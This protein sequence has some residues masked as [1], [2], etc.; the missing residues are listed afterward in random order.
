MQKQIIYIFLLLSVNI[1]AQPLEQLLNQV[2]E[3]NLS[4]KVLE[5]NYY[6]ALEKAPQVSQRPDPEIGIG[7]FPLPVETRLGGQT[8]RLSA[9]QMF[10]W[11]GT[12]EDKEGVAIA[13]ARV[14]HQR[15]SAEAL[16][17]Q[18]Q[19]EQAY[20]QLYESK[21]S[22]RIIERNL[23]LLEALERLALV[24]VESGSAIA[25]DVLRVQ[26][27][28][29]ALKQE[30]AIWKTKFVA[31][32]TTINQILNRP[33]N[34]SIVTK[35]S[36]VFAT[37][38][39]NRDSLIKNIAANHPMLHVMALQQ[40]VAKQEIAVNKSGQKPSF[41]VGLDY[42]TVD[43]RSDAM[44]VRN[45]RDI[46]QIKGVLRIPL[47]KGKFEA[48]EKEEQFK[49]EAINHKK[50]NLLTQFKANIEKAFAIYEAA[51]LQV[52]L[53]QQQIALTKASIRILETNYSTNGKSFDE[54][55]RLQKDLID[56]DLK[57]LRAIVQSHLAK[58]DMER[59]ISY[60]IK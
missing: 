8:L 20:F 15:I 14:Q 18:Y 28:V 17:L 33:L 23:V 19:I 26:L 27:Q 24:K 35:D 29:A 32:T 10:P 58:S 48:K 59:Y 45:G 31:P 60:S 37:L 51:Q 38:Y 25:A 6:A 5:N 7:V 39:Y 41:G 57:I 50:T 53:Y 30:I 36:L 43:K 16:E 42:I 56:Y 40:E 2:A 55:L 21:Q 12:L 9:M 44:P 47:Y 34:Q 54:L 46:L 22:Q 1:A 52:D 4:L 11:P 13:N 49:I 3:N